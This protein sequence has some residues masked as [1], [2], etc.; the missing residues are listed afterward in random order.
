MDHDEIVAA[1]QSSWQQMTEIFRTAI[2]DCT[3]L[4]EARG[5][6]NDQAFRMAH[7]M[8]Q[9]EIFFT[10]TIMTVVAKQCKEKK[11]EAFG[12][13]ESF[14]KWVTREFKAWENEAGKA[15]SRDEAA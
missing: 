12:G 8:V 9:Q 15:V 10:H 4:L 11:T 13:G 6:N 14:I 3:K 1:V 7:F 5:L 2:E